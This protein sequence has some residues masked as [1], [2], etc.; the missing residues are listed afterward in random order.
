MGTAGIIIWVLTIGLFVLY[1]FIAMRQ[2][3]KAE[4]SFS[5]YAIGGGALP[6]YL[7]F[8]SHF[9]NIMGVGN[10][11]G[12]AGSA[13]VNGLPWLV[14]I[15]GEQGS[16]IIF[17]LVFAGMAGKMTYNTFPEMIDDLITR[18]KITRALC[19]L[20]ASSIMIAWI[21]GQG[22]AFGQLFGVFT[23]IS[24]TPIILLFTAMFVFY[25]TMGGMLS[26]VWMDFVQGLIC[27]VFGSLFYL[28]A[29]SK[30]DFSFAVLGAR[31]AEVGKAEL[32]SFAGTDT[33]S[34]I[35]KFVTGCVGILVAQ[36]Y[37]QPCFAAKNPKIAKRSMLYGGSVAI[38]MTMCT[39]VVGLIIL[40]M[41]QGLSQGEA[42]SWFMLN[43]VP[44]I[45]TI[46]LFVLILAAGMSSAD[47]NLNSAAI[48]ISNDLI[49]TFKTDLNDKQ[50]IKL[51]R[52]LTVIIGAIAALGGIYAS[53]IMSLFSKAYSMAGAGLV[54]LLIIGLLWKEDSSTG[55]TMGKKNS[56]VTPW[57]SRVGIVVGAVLSQVTALGPNA[58]LIA[59]AASAVCIIVI[60]LLTR[61]ISN[62]PK[63]VSE[64][65]VNPMQKAY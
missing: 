9:A 28:V 57:G 63:F 1:F 51:T 24:P 26:L 27:I 41:N 19:G 43:E 50:M 11:M 8:F 58:I 34:I 30:I 14:F 65:N 44:L 20:L 47:S 6:F 39:A 45:V 4:E 32:F 54:P 13:Y 5:N 36:I 33:I 25:T 35:T 62:N 49:K 40:T 15:L 37:W 23:G 21:G 18:D 16:K 46:M 52:T 61:N 59:L 29:F 17:A 2:K 7:L 3:S 55:P 38:I 10:F 64:G 31:L 53:S 48:L 22:K 60:S 42:M 12:H 56:K